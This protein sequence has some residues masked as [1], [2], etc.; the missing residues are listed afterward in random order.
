MAKLNLLVLA[1]SFV[2]LS[3]C[4][5]KRQQAEAPPPTPAQQAQAALANE[6]DSY[7]NQT[8]SRI[9]EMTKFASDLR[10][11]AETAQKPQK[12]KLQNAADDM[13]SSLKDV[14]KELTD[15]RE[16]APENWIDEKR[17]VTKTMQR[18]ETQFSNSIRLLQ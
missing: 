12:K 4:A 11:K 5:H 10:A 8:Q 9:D 14:E 15:V 18:A 7:V 6:R 17:D 13:D 3:S 16:A 2:A 1:V